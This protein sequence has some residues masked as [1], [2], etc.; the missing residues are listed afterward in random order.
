MAVANERLLRKKK[1][2]HTELKGLIEN[3]LHFREATST[4][5]SNSQFH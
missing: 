3:D 5:A 1:A 2:L 4:V